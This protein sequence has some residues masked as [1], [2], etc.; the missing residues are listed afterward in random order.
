M[1]ARPSQ[2]LSRPGTS[3][4]GLQVPYGPQPGPMTQGLTAPGLDPYFS[5]IGPGGGPGGYQ[6]PVDVPAIN[7][8]GIPNV[9]PSVEPTGGG[10]PLPE[11]QSRNM[12]LQSP[13]PE[14]MATAPVFGRS[15]GG[16]GGGSPGMATAVQVA[17]QQA[18]VDFPQLTFWQ[19]MAL[20]LNPE[21]G[22]VYLQGIERQRKGRLA[23][24]VSDT[25]DA[26]VSLM[27]QGDFAGARKL[28]SQMMRESQGDPETMQFIDNHQ[29]SL[30]QREMAW[31]QAQGLVRAFDGMTK[32]VNPDLVN[33]GLSNIM[34]Q[35]RDPE[36]GSALMLQGPEGI[37]QLVDILAQRDV[38]INLEGRNAY[39]IDRQT[40]QVRSVPLD[41]A[42]SSKDFSAS[43]R[44]QLAHL[45]KMTDRDLENLM[46]KDPARALDIHQKVREAGN[47]MDA[48]MKQQQE[49][50]A[51]LPQDYPLKGRSAIPDIGEGETVE[52]YVQR[53]QGTQARVV[54]TEQQTGRERAT[55]QEGVAGG[56][57]INRQTYELDP[58]AATRPIN[59]NVERGLAQIDEDTYKKVVALKE[60]SRLINQLVQAFEA[61]KPTGTEPG[62]RATDLWKR[63][64]AVAE[65]YVPG[66][67][68]S[69]KDSI[70][71]TS[72]NL[73]NSWLSRYEFVQ[74][75]TSGA[76][77][78]RIINEMKGS[79]RVA[80]Q[81]TL[82]LLQKS[83]RQQ[84]DDLLGQGAKP[85]AVPTEPP[86]GSTTTPGGPGTVID[87]TIRE[88]D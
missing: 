62:S 76:Q 5:A 31:S 79:N 55:R 42:Y 77:T 28:W 29:R 38:Q 45:Y 14:A 70:A 47:A 54:A 7:V 4:L 58:D 17:A 88:L 26:E 61:M 40:G 87:P 81:N 27:K 20:N 48:R 83:Y 34:A 39:I 68:M 53:K 59:A 57:W 71:T 41:V 43:Q 51:I 65:E 15:M 49:A 66:L 84:L 16:G 52:A 46:R 9:V 50:P 11:I 32:G 1:P 44:D 78:R 23:G 74:Q 2:T 21:L 72:A 8:A 73:L 35:L 63:L 12:I 86:A 19:K 24:R 82:Q 30:M 6:N 36:S 75:S 25:M 69:E 13:E 56:R 22:R 67:T 3:A 10:F 33:P 64:T 37:K 18:G 60:G 80:S 85:L